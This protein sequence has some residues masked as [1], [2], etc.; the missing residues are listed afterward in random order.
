MPELPTP[1]LTRRL[2]WGCVW[3]DWMYVNWALD[4]PALYPLHINYKETFTIVL[5]VC[6]WAPFWSGYRVI[7]KSD[8]QV[9]TDILNKGSSC[10]PMIMA[11][12]GYLF[13]LKKYFSFSVFVEHIPGSILHLMMYVTGQSSKHGSPSPL[14]YGTLNLTCRHYLLHSLDPRDEQRLHGP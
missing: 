6:R 7:V 5:A 4:H 8:S 14:H 3:T 2:W 9:A 10:C 13:W 11:W 12:I 1:V